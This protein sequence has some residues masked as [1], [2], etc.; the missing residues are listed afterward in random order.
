[1]FRWWYRHRAR[2]LRKA[3]ARWQES[4]DFF[5][6]RLRTEPLGSPEWEKLRACSIS[7]HFDV[8]RIQERREKVEAR[9]R[10][11]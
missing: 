6:D 4:V 7:C 2:A 1:M 10:P 5:N 3:E 11:A 8:L 9:L